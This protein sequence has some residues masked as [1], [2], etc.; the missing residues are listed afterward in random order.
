MNPL[1]GLPLVLRGLLVAIL[2]SGGSLLAH[3]LP[4]SYMRLTVT[5]EYLH[6]E[7]VFNPFELTFMTELDENQDAELSLAELE[8]HGPK[9]AQ[10]L[11]DAL[12]VSANG[13]PLTAES[14]GMDPE[15]TGHHVRLRAHYKADVRQRRLSLES[16]LD[17]LTSAS[18]LTQ[19]TYINGDQTQRAQLDTHS[20]RVTFT[21]AS[22]PAADPP[23]PPPGPRAALGLFLWLLAIL[24]LLVS[25]AG[26]LLWVRRRLTL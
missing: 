25:T 23:P 8:T 21:P 24:A 14:A 4:I 19:V 7:L 18:H 22:S 10:R 16:K 15:L 12:V 17:T 9:L 6:L 5:P 26:V 20:R 11:V 3:T 13:Q 2:L 1:R